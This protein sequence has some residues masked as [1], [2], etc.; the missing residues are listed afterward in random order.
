MSITENNLEYALTGE[1]LAIQ[2]Y[3]NYSEKAMEEG[4]SNISLLFRVIAESEF[5]HA[6][7][8]LKASA[9]STTRENLISA[10]DIEKREITDIYPAYIKQASSENNEKAAVSFNL[11]RQVEKVH[12]GLFQVAL[13]KLDNGKTEGPSKF[14]VCQYCGNV[15]EGEAPDQCPICGSPKNMYKPVV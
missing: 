8:H 4:L 9:L 1:S 13:R 14:S 10:I 7:N 6:K 15:V 11:A 5:V 12:R 2:K 3:L